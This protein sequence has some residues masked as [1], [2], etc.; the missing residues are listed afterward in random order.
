VIC[1]YCREPMK[2]ATTDHFIAISKGGC[3]HPHNK[4]KCCRDCNNKKSN[5]RAID[6]LDQM[7]MSDDIIWMRRIITVQQCIFFD[8]C[9]YSK[10]K[11][12]IKIHKDTIKQLKKNYKDLKNSIKV[13]DAVFRMYHE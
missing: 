5:M 4:V 11:R 3:N 6:W 13:S 12:K 10:L 1:T 9:D 7:K 8:G 2:D